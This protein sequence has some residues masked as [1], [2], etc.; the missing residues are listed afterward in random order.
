MKSVISIVFQRLL[1]NS[2]GATAMLKD[3]AGGQNSQNR[4]QARL[5]CFVPLASAEVKLILYS[6]KP[7]R[8]TGRWRETE[9]DSK[10]VAFRPRQACRELKGCAAGP[11][12]F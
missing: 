9:H 6:K 7:E 1:K 11:A 5:I 8:K 12:S 10:A 2:Y 4:G 3:S